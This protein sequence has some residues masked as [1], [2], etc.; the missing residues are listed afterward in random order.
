VR[1]LVCGSRTWGREKDSEGNV[2]RSRAA[3]QFQRDMIAD[4][5]IGYYTDDGALVVIEGAAPG[6]DTVAGEWATAMLYDEKHLSYPADWKRYGKDAGPIRNAQM[7]DEGKPD[8][9]VAFIDQPLNE[10]KGTA[11][12]V[13]RSRAAGVPTYVITDEAA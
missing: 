7:L 1:V 10:S 12:M 13:R 5:L 9:V 11:D 2:I 4:V 6:A 3:A 8:L